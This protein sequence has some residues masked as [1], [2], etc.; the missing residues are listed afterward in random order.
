MMKK[1]GISGVPQYRN[2]DSGDFYPAD[3]FT[4]LIRA[5]P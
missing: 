1:N 2:F 5:V 4:E 3:D